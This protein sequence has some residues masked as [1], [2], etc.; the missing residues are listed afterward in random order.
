ML[1]DFFNNPILYLS[2]Y[3]VGYTT[4]MTM[5]IFS[6][7]FTA[8]ENRIPKLF[9]RLFALM[10][11]IIPP[12]VLPLTKGP[13]I[14]VTES[15]SL[16]IGIL[17][18]LLNFI[19]KVMAQKKIGTMPA[20]KSKRKVI[21]TG[22]YSVVRNPLYLSNALLAFGMAALFNSLYGFL[23]SILY[24]ILYLPIIYFEEK[25]LSKKYGKKYEKYKRK[26][27]WKMIPSVF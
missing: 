21:T 11:F 23:F 4:V 26:V 2:I 3:V 7:L 5:F 16:I 15:I 10:T 8:V 27:R 14:P 13:E 24:T 1:I 22:I 6:K 25:D 12:V 17:F 9:M 20:L 18:L 19:L